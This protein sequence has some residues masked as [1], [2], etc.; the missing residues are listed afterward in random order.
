VVESG[1]LAGKLSAGGATLVDDGISCDRDG[2]LDPGESGT[3][4]LRL[5]NNGV[6]AAEDV[7]VTA[8]TT[9]AGVRVGAPLRL[10][11]VQPFTAS[12]LAIPVTVLQNAPR[13]TLVTINV[14]IAGE[15]VCE[16]DGINLSL[17]IRTGADD[18]PN[19]SATDDAETK[20]LAWT[21]T[22]TA[23]A[24]LWGKAVEAGGANQSFFGR[25]SPV[26]SDTQ[27]LSPPLQV[28]T[29]QPFIVNLKHAFNLQG[30]APTFQDGG[31]IEISLNGGLT[32]NDVTAFGINPGYTGTLIAAN[33]L[34]ARPAFSGISPGFPARSALTLNFG[35]V[36]A[37]LTVQLRFRLGTNATV[38]AVGW[39]ID[40]I[41][42][43]GINNT[44][45]P[46]LVP[47]PS[48]CTARDRSTAESGVLATFA[49]PATSLHAF[50]AAV[51]IL[52][53]SSP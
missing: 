6:L 46:R 8:T 15:F 41:A 53:E 49:A 22:G 18:E 11:L 32:F 26:T 30:A 29:T 27:F 50:D 7:V 25:N 52:A 45:F 21:P 19:A 39:D 44:P 24:T 4:R 40:D 23:A 12:D 42:V 16:K 37:G 47:E 33:P 31:V 43:S 34:G 3:L 17:T 10:N 14:H 5:A 20:L 9:N 48:T 51:C 36:L 38:A 1:T 35:N 28:S 2:Y 13:N